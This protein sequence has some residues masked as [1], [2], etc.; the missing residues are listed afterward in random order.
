[1][2]GT[3]G[4]VSP[5]SRTGV[6]RLQVGK[7]IPL[8]YPVNLLDPGESEIRPR[9]SDTAELGEAGAIDASGEGQAEVWRFLVLAALVVLLLEWLLLSLRGG[10]S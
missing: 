9:G 6:Y 4:V 3:D 7:G 2:T 10:T 8:P 5:F 1:V